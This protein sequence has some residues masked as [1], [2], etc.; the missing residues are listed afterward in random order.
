MC[1]YICIYIYVNIYIYIYIVQVS[2][3]RKDIKLLVICSEIPCSIQL[4]GCY[5]MWDLSVRNLGI[6]Y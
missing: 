2:K 1:I 5:M 3:K 4:T 6:D